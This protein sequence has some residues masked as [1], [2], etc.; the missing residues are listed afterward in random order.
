LTSAIEP[1]DKLLTSD[2]THETAVRR[3]MVLLTQLD[4]RGE[5]IRA[6]QRLASILKR[7]YESEPLPETVELYKALR[8][9]QIQ[10]SNLVSGSPPVARLAQ[11]DK[12]KRTRNHSRFQ[13]GHNA[14]DT[15]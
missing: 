14:S 8:Q 13:E 15:P 11:T 6:Y 9:G 4:R 3:L 12:D 7:D 1:L 5:A 2:P 10:V